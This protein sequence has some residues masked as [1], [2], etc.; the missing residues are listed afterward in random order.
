MTSLMR[1][2]FDGGED[3]RAKQVEFVDARNRRYHTFAPDC[4][5][6]VAAPSSSRSSA[7]RPPVNR[8]ALAALTPK[9]V[10]DWLKEHGLGAWGAAFVAH[11]VCGHTLSRGI[12]D[13]LLIAVGVNLKVV[14]QRI[15]TLVSAA[16]VHGV[17]FFASSLSGTRPKTAPCPP[18]RPRLKRPSTS[19]TFVVPE[20]NRVKAT[21]EAIDVDLT[22]LVSKA[23]LCHAIRISTNLADAAIADVVNHLPQS[24]EPD[25]FH[26]DTLP[27]F[28]SRPPPPEV[29]VVESDQKDD[30]VIATTPDSLRLADKLV[31]KWKTLTKLLVVGDKGNLKCKLRKRRGVVALTKLRDR[32]DTLGIRLSPTELAFVTSNF[33]APSYGTEPL[34]AYPRLLKFV[35][36]TKFLRPPTASS[37]FQDDNNRPC[38]A[39]TATEAIHHHHHHNPEEEEQHHR[40]SDDDN[41]RR[42]KEETKSPLQQVSATTHG[43]LV[44][45]CQHA[46]QQQ[47]SE[48]ESV[49]PIRTFRNILRGHDIDL[50]EDR[51]YDLLRDHADQRAVDYRKALRSLLPG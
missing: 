41:V 7:T 26:Y 21:C 46:A 12:S 8:T 23:E 42:I 5:T 22:G 51:M 30:V 35:A 50:G 31:P 24:G 48:D 20:K 17:D 32:L 45:A 38:T 36:D 44:L 49:V 37:S 34:I 2:S 19:R 29:V 1:P 11:G 10:G 4:G 25:F 15:H 3:R 33:L 40:L 6:V 28:A 18:Q 16:R 14:R 13:D 9:Q 47:Q 27:E 43:A 39:T